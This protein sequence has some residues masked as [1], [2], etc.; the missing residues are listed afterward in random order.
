MRADV[1]IA[2][3]GANYELGQ[4]PQFYGIWP[5]SASDSQPME[6]WPKTP[7]GW[8]GAWARFVTLELPGTIRPVGRTAQAADPAGGVTRVGGAAA[9]GVEA[10]SEV[11]GPPAGV[12]G[13]GAAGGDTAASDPSTQFFGAVDRTASSA[14][15][16][17]GRIRARVAPALLAAGIGLGVAGLFPSYLGG[18]SL[19]QQAYQLV[20]HLIYLLAWGLSGGLIALGGTRLRIGAL[21]AVGTSIVT[22]GLYLTD[23]GQVIAHLNTGGPGL[24]LAFL[25]WLACA[26]G[27]GLAFSIRPHGRPGRPD[28]RELVASVTLMV[29]GLGAAIA[30]AP[31]W[32]SFLLQWSGG[33]ATRT[34]GDAFSYPALMIAGSVLVMIG[35]IA[36]VVAAALWRPVRHGGVLVLGAAIPLAAQA[37]SALLELRLPTPPQ[38]FGISPAEAAAYGLTISNGVTTMFWVYCGFVVTLALLAVRM[39]IV[40][41]AVP[42]MHGGPGRSAP[43]AAAPA[44]Q[45][46]PAPWWPQAPG[47]PGPVPQ[48]GDPQSTTT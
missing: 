23:A 8:S 6:W 40:E 28:R 12:E 38:T 10:P 15:E 43:D 7:A 45:P 3:Q 13:A 32:D 36:A 44:L 5:A 1:D 25:G 4:G 24:V 2:Y 37:I 17:A 30:F 27:S 48:G 34:A 42:V 20:P 35:I 33:S 9:V 39:L 16:S 21:L 41:P 18:Q 19:A 46:L 11:G 26:A 47:A 14:T 31:A 22:F 29:A